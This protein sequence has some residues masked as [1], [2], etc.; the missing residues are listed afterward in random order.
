M[1]TNDGQPKT[2]VVNGVEVPHVLADLDSDLKLF[3]DGYEN[4]ILC[5]CVAGKENEWQVSLLKEIVS[6]MRKLRLKVIR[7][8]KARGCCPYKEEDVQCQS[9]VKTASGG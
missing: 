7:T 1:A 8:M 3:A 9:A 4:E 2:F 6:Y 5:Q